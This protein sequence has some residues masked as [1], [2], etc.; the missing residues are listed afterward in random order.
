MG[1]R[2]QGSEKL[3]HA[4]K[5]G[6]YSPFSSGLGLCIEDRGGRLGARQQDSVKLPHAIRKGVYSSGLGLCIISYKQGCVFTMLCIVPIYRDAREYSLLDSTLPLQFFSQG[7]F[8]GLMARGSCG[9]LA[10]KEAPRASRL[11]PPLCRE[12]LAPRVAPGH[13]YYQLDVAWPGF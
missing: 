9:A 6:V 4:I 5:K 8:L 10:K 13:V 3:Q 12:R 11:R 1:E 7:Y 2:Q